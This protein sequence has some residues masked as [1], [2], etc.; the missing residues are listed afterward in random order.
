MHNC[1]ANDTAEVTVGNGTHNVTKTI[2]APG[3]IT[4][5]YYRAVR[6]FDVN[7]SYN[8]SIWLHCNNSKIEADPAGCL[9]IA[10][11]S[12]CMAQKSNL[13]RAYVK[14]YVELARLIDTYEQMCWSTAEEDALEDEYKN[15]KGPLQDEND[16]L[17]DDIEKNTEGLQGL[18][19]KLQDALNA[20]ARLRKHVKELSDKC[21][22]LNA[23]ESSLDEVRAAIQALQAC[24]GFVGRP[25]FHIPK[26]VGLTKFTLHNTATDAE[27]DHAMLAACQ[28]DI[29][30]ET[31][32]A[33]VGEIEAHAIEGMPLNN[34]ADVA[35]IG[36]CPKCEGGA[37]ADTGMSN[38][39]KHARV[40]WFPG[41]L[42]NAANRKDCST[43]LKAVMCITDRGD[44]RKIVWTGNHTI[45]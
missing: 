38:L 15:K 27:N 39:E 5:G 1:S 31:H 16:K 28:A 6:C 36:S 4:H 40:C 10:D 33:E 25:E 17:S 29:G 30:P 42:L 14:A 22:T 37:D 26:F 43:H 12:S 9:A 23:T 18:K 21:S 32:P 8:G 2:A 45:S 19:P 35:L 41:T 3:E 44:A 24:P 34:T 7:P 11:N 20:E 13:E